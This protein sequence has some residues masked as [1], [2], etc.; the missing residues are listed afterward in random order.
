MRN[1]AEAN[2]ALP[3]K[4]VATLDFI[5]AFAILQIVVSHLYWRVDAA[6]GLNI[7]LALAGY[8]FA[9]FTL[10][11]TNR[12]IV[13]DLLFY[14][15][16]LA[17]P[18]LALTLI[19][20]VV[21][22][23]VDFYELIFVSAAVNHETVSGYPIWYPQ[24]IIAIFLALAV[25]ARL[26]DLKG[27]LRHSKIFSFGL[28]VVTA[29]IPVAIG[30]YQSDIFWAQP[31]YIAWNF[32]L[33]WVV[34]FF[35]QTEENARLWKSL[36]MLIVVCFSGFVF[37]VAFDSQLSRWVF[38]SISIAAILTTTKIRV[39]GFI[40]SSVRV[41]ASASIYLFFLHLPVF[42]LMTFLFAGNVSR[43]AAF[44][45]AFGGAVFLPILIWSLYT[46]GTRAYQ[47]TVTV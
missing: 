33:G 29:T 22:Q 10:Y 24:A 45:L 12:D 18:S 5:R 46:A 26:F 16:K 8:N 2:G 11:K 25:F 4:E 15:R 32:F 20:S 28:L 7:L 35:S 41:L 42:E 34:Y 31:Q 36:V 23:K 19:Y 47:Q 30:L 1:N 17:L 40:Q 38:L 27:F 43:S 39:P 37:V 13:T 21:R 9:R 6:G 44:V 14:V 3:W